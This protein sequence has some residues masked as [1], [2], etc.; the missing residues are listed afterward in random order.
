MAGKF[1]KCMALC[2]TRALVTEEIGKDT[3]EE[4]IAG[5]NKLLSEKTELKPVAAAKLRQ[6]TAE[7]AGPR[8]IPLTTDP[9]ERIRTGFA[10]FKKEKYEKDPALYAKLAKGQS[11]EAKHSGTGAAIEFAVLHLKVKNILVIGHSCCGGIKGLMSITDDAT[12][13]SDF[14]EAWVKICKAAKAKVQN[15]CSKVDLDKQCRQLEKEAVNVSLGNLLSY[16]FVR[17]AVV[18]NTLSLKGAHYDFVKGTFDIWGL[19]SQA[20][21][22]LSL[23]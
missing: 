3:C 21:P 18:K 11:P 6:L 7:L 10:H 23:Q 14:I 2:C 16:P 19:E 4:A 20:S 22:Y 12:N 15:E 1:K 9:V 5:L 13:N 8:G 17:E